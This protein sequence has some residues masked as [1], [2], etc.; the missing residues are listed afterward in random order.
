M[1]EKDSKDF[2]KTIINYKLSNKHIIKFITKYVGCSKGVG[3]NWYQ[4]LKP[5]IIVNITKMVK[6][7]IDKYHQLIHTHAQKK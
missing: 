6:H 3:E 5:S 1:H 7:I 2:R 4:E